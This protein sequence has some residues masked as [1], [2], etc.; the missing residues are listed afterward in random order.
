MRETGRLLALEMVIPAGPAQPLHGLADLQALT[1][2][3]GG[4]Q[5]RET[6]TALMAEAGLDLASVDPADGPYS[7]LTATPA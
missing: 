4:D 1:V 2:Y 7:W 3:G 6:W 5:D